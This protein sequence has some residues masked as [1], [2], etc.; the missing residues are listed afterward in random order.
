MTW[1]V[2]GFRWCLLGVGGMDWTGLGITA[3]FAVL[4]LLGG[5]FYFR[6]MESGFADII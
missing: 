2:Q 1:V 3:V 5:L 4:V 6:R